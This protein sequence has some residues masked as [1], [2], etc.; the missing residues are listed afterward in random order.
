MDEKRI[1]DW[2]KR[3][4]IEARISIDVKKRIENQRETRKQKHKRNWTSDEK[5]SH[6]THS[7]QRQTDE[8]IKCVRQVFFL[9]CLSSSHAS[10]APSAERRRY[11]ESKT[12]LRENKK[13]TK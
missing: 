2:N 12:V 8:T 6:T 4:R 3:A 7:T 5:F 10:Y 13:K 9:R 11:Q 1:R